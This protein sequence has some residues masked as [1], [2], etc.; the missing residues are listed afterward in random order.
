[1]ATATFGVLA[2]LYFLFT[3]KKWNVIEKNGWR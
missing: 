2:V 1:L 3:L